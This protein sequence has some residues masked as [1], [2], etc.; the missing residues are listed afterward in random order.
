MLPG[1][2]EG[3]S[4]Q[5]LARVLYD[6]TLDG[7]DQALG[8]VQDFGWYG[9]ILHVIKGNLSKGRSYIV[10]EDSQGF[11]NYTEYK[12][13]QSALVAWAKL[14]SEYADFEAGV[15]MFGSE[16]EKCTTPNNCQGCPNERG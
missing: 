1:K 9:L 6:L 12:N 16:C 5:D 4:D 2:F 7:Y 8:D 3:N 10:H 11:F 13:K 14:E 15:D